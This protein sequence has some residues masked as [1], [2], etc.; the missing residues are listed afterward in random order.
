MVGSKSIPLSEVLQMDEEQLLVFTV[1]RIPRT[2]ALVLTG[3]GLSVAGFIMQQIAQNKFVSPTT[4]GS[5]DAAKLGILVGLIAMPSISLTGKIFFSLIF[6]FIC[7]L[8]FILLVKR[9]KV[10]DIIIVPLLG[11]M[12]GNV[13]SAIATFFGV[14]YNIVQNMQG[15]MLGDFSSVLQ[16]QYESIYLIVPVVIIAYIFAYQFT[17]VG[18]GESFAKNLGINYNFFLYTGLI[19]VSLTVSATV[20]TV[21]AIPFLGLVVPNVVRIY[22]GDNLKRNLF[23]VAIYGALF[24]L[25]SDIFGRWVIAPYEIPIGMMVGI[26]GGI[27]FFYLIFRKNN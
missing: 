14:K 16:G 27:I 2:L 23:Y 9:I 20:V 25:V 13:L 12:F 10:K 26:V 6:G 24:L 4:A 11:I 21:G 22:M 19:V 1:S 17:L 18:I 7:S 8:I 15:W 5:L 3:I